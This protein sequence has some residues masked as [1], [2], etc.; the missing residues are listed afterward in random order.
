MNTTLWVLQ[1]ILAVL[2]PLPAF[3]ALMRWQVELLA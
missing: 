2:Y 3:V 1:S